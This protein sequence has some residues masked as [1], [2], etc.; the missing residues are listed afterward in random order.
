MQTNLTCYQLK[1]DCYIY[2]W[3]IIC[4]PHVTTKENPIVDTQKI[5]EPKHT[6]ESQTTSE[7][8]RE[9][10]RNRWELQ[11]SQKIINKMS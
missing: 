6:K 9:E 10:K 5:K 1:I 11:N 3:V 8:A 2:I 7:R 4:K